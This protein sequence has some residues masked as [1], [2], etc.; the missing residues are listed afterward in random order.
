VQLYVDWY[1]LSLSGAP[2]LEL[3]HVNS[4]FLVPY[5]QLASVKELNE[6]Q[7]IDANQ[8]LGLIISS[9]TTALPREGHYF[10]FNA[11]VTPVSRS[12]QNSHKYDFCLLY[13]NMKKEN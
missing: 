5:T 6:T 11:S 7:I 13:C 12:G 1:Q 4:Q 2:H 10:L 3:L 8:S 9:S